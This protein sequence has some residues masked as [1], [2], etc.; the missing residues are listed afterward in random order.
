MIDGGGAEGYGRY[1]L[2][3]LPN[4]YP[5]GHQ[6]RR[7]VDAPAAAAGGGTVPAFQSYLPGPNG[8]GGLSN[9]A[10][11]AASSHSGII[12]ANGVGAIGGAIA[13]LGGAV[14]RLGANYGLAADA[15]RGRRKVRLRGPHGT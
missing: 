13:G 12:S 10:R 14:A 4:G 6:H 7:G 1:S 3:G 2:G 11:V 15:R 9:S 5:H 8:V